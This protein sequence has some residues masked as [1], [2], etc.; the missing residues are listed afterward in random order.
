MSG[1]GPDAMRRSVSFDST[2]LIGLSKDEIDKMLFESAFAADKWFISVITEMEGLSKKGIVANEQAFIRDFFKE[3]KI[4]PLNRAIK[5]IAID[6][7]C[8]THLKL[9]DS[10]IAATAI[11]TGSL[12]VSNDQHLLQAEYPGL[13][14]EG[15]ERKA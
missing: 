15:F 14:V 13:R 7:R 1:I 5:D 4:I 12:L 11:R 9:P 10:I 2:I 6:F 3:C 8:Q